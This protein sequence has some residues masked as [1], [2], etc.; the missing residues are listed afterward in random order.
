[1]CTIPSVHRLTLAQQKLSVNGVDQGQLVGLRAPSSDYPVQNVNDAN[2][3]CGQSGSRSNKV[4]NV[5]AGDKI[6]A[7]WGHVLGGAQR[8]GDPDHPI[9]KSHKGPIMYYLAKVDD[10]A[11]ASS[12]GLK[13]FKID[14]DT[15]DTKT[16][17]W[18]VDN[19]I[20]QNGWSYA[21]IPECIAPGQYL[22]RAELLAL[23]SAYS[24]GGAQFYQSCAQ[25]NISSSGTF[26]PTQTVAF[27]GAYKQND[28]SILVQI[29]STASQITAGSP[30]QRLGRRLSPAERGGRRMAIITNQP[31]D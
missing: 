25:L 5:K 21:K 7:G 13:W 30:T 24:S 12:A 26:V 3:A 8:P 10:A 9:A 14:E 19:M 15:F 29:W 31:W 4:I 16:A 1:M 27:P 28:P 11:S 20:A 17:K 18:G 2:M 22:M 23:H 6:G